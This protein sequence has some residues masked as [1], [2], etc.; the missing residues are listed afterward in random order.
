V[1]DFNQQVI[2]EFRANGGKVERFG[3]APVTLMHLTGAKSGEPR[4]TPV[5]AFPLDDRLFVVASKAG[6]PEHPAWYHNLLAH[7]RFEIEVGTER[8]EVEAVPVTGAERDALYAQV[9]EVMPGFGA[10]QEQT[11]R[12]IPIVELRRV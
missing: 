7:P 4:L 12:V 1:S 3:S 5:V 10:Y 11:S 6:A 2:D 9:V 8:Y